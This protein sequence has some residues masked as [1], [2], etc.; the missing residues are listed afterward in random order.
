MKNNYSNDLQ[1]RL[2][3]IKIDFSLVSTMP[4]LNIKKVSQ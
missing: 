3:I 1:P 2:Y 4:E